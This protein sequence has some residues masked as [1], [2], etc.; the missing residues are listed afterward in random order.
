MSLSA[1]VVIP[2]YNKL[3]RLELVLESF[4]FQS[5]APEKFELIIVDDGSS[6]G[7]EIMI[8]NIKTEFQINYIKQMNSGRSHAR[9]AGISKA[10]SSIIIFC[11]DDCIVSK[12]FVKAHINAHTFSDNCVVHGLINNLPY[13]KFF[14]NPT[15]GELYSEEDDRQIADLTFLSRSLISL[16]DIKDL[17]K[18]V[19]QKKTTFFEKQIIR[20]F[21]RDYRE[22]KWLGCTGGNFSC[23]KE[24]LMQVGSF[25]EELDQRWGGEDLELGYRLYEAGAVFEFCEE[26]CNYHMAH[27]RKT[28]E[29]DLRFSIGKFFEK[30]KDS[31]VMNLPLLLLGQVKS[32]EEYMKICKQVEAGGR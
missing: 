14:K 19:G 12:D 5:E 9:N 26:A 1:S 32:V 17:L 31:F 10:K 25:D 30:H 24:L 6:D 11:D 7:T 8:N 21:E 28:F 23:P 15:T 18:I 27:F 22:L 29:E 3:Q 13:L 2:T 4:K 16:S 20:I